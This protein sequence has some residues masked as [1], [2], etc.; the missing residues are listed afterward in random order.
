MRLILETW[1]YWCRTWP[2]NRQHVAAQLGCAHVSG[3]LNR[4]AFG[5]LRSLAERCGSWYL[6]QQRQRL[7]ITVTSLWV[8]WIGDKPLFVP[9]V[10]QFT[11]GYA[12][13]SLNELKCRSQLWFEWFWI[14]SLW[15][16]NIFILTMFVGG[17]WQDMMTWWCKIVNSRGFLYWSPGVGPW[18]VN[19]T[20][21][22]VKP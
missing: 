4:W 15:L 9:F 7:S 8:W 13:L 10:A 20:F 14:K 18:S 6:G 16:R 21:V 12:S 2:A 17:L 22:A 11:D 3:S 1:R 19:R 5:N